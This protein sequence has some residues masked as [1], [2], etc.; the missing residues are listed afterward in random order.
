MVKAKKNSIKSPP[1]RTRLG[2]KR[3]VSKAFQE[4]LGELFQEVE[5][6]QFITERRFLNHYE[7]EGYVLFAMFEKRG[8]YVKYLQD[9]K[10]LQPAPG[11]FIEQELAYY[12]HEAKNAVI[13]TKPTTGTFGYAHLKNL[14]L[15]RKT[16][17]EEYYLH[18]VY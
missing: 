14:G 7:N 9:A 16:D 6:V 18:V 15:I 12:F 13:M 5:E 17:K 1:A 2:R 4:L 3:L 8:L 11:Y 10:E